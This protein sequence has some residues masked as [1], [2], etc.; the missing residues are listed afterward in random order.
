M[1]IDPRPGPEFVNNPGEGPPEDPYTPEAIEERDG[2]LFLRIRAIPGAGRT[3][4]GGVRRGAII[5]RVNAPP[6]KGRANHAIERALAAALDLPRRTVAL[7][8]GERSREK[9]FR[10]EG[11]DRADLIRR[12][13]PLLGE[14]AN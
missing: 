1:G 5:V 2:S 12:V 11:V 7:D 10:I 9:R 14:S 6:E 8:S 4:V 13:T 3:E